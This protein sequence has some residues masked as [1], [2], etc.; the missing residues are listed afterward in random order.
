MAVPEGVN[1]QDGYVTVYTTLNKWAGS[2]E[3]AADGSYTVGGVGIRF[4]QGAGPV[5]RG[6]CFP[7]MVG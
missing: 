4:V 6:E 2:S 7:A 1:V 3:V 5:L